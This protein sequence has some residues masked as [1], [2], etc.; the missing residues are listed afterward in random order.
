[1]FPG[2]VAVSKT[3][4]HYSSDCSAVNEIFKLFFPKV[5]ISL[6]LIAAG[7]ALNRSVLP[8]AVL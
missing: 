8:E 3:Q 4:S 5:T 2:R 1:M 7:S 6:K